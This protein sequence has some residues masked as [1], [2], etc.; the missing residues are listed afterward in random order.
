MTMRGP[1]EGT[2]KLTARA[3]VETEDGVYEQPPRLPFRIGLWAI[4]AL[5]IALYVARGLLPE[6]LLMVPLC[7]YLIYRDTFPPSPAGWPLLSLHGTRLQ[8]GQGRWRRAGADLSGVRRISLY[9]P[10]HS[11]LG[12][13]YQDGSVRKLYPDWRQAERAAALAFLRR[14]LGDRVEVIEREPPGWMEDVRGQYEP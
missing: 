2:L 7:G 14:R 4:L 1:E 10:G 13:V 5:A 12:L 3:L 9:G 6:L 8:L 11:V